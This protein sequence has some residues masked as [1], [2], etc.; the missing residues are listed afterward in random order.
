M[1][2]KHVT[3][4]VHCWNCGDPLPEPSLTEVDVARTL[5]ESECGTAHFRYMCVVCVG[6][7]VR[8]CLRGI[9]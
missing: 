2:A 9:V 8:L 7:G 5:I 6:N 4:S 3:R 1:P